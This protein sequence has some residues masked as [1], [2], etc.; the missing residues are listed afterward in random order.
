M[1]GACSSQDFLAFAPPPPLGVDPGSNAVV[2]HAG[3][4]SERR[5]TFDH[6]LGPATTQQEVQLGAKHVQHVALLLLPRRR[7]MRQIRLWRCTAQSRPAYA[8]PPL[9][10]PVPRAGV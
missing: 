3:K 1:P 5:Q 7:G 10:C 4:K 6:V 8:N 2:S 9:P